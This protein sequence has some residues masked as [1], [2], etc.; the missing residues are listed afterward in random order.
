MGIILFIVASIL[1]YILT[2]PF[3]IG[4]VLLTKPTKWSKYFKNIAFAIDQLGNVMGGPLMN[5]V[6]LKKEPIEYFGNVDETI[7]HIVG[8][9]YLANK[10]TIFGTALAKILDFFEKDHVEKAAI[11]NQDNTKE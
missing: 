4:G 3:L 8:V 2:L 9:N 1:L 7:S 5:F 6:L 11:T 10:T